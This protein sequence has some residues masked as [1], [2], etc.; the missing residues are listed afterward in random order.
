METD[1]P[2]KVWY[3]FIRIKS[4]TSKNIVN[5]TLTTKTAS[6]G[7]RLSI[8]SLVSIYQN[9]EYHVKEYRKFD[10]HHQD[11]FK[12]DMRQGVVELLSFFY[13]QHGNKRAATSGSYKP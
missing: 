13:S 8:E 5:L 10:P 9:K 12:C 3:R 1:F 2:S 7:D 4:I 11:N 6:D